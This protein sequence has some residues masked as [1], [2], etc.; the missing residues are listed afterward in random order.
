MRCKIYCLLDN[1]YAIDVTCIA[2]YDKFTWSELSTSERIYSDH[3][4]KVKHKIFKSETA[5]RKWLK[6]YIRPRD[7]DDFFKTEHLSLNMFIFLPTGKNP[8]V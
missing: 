5:A 4:Y 1:S 7:N 8:Y 3:L 2:S 6:W